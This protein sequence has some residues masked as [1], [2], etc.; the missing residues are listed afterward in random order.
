MAEAKPISRRVRR[1]TPEEALTSDERRPRSPEV[2]DVVVRQFGE[3]TD[4]EP[5]GGGR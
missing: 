5:A 2:D 1:G 3:D 4:P